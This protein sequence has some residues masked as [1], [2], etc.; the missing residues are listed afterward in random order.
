MSWRNTVSACLSHV[1][2]GRGWNSGPM[3]A[4]VTPFTTRI[5]AGPASPSGNV[6]LVVEGMVKRSVKHGPGPAAQSSTVTPATLTTA[7]G[8]PA[9]RNVTVTTFA[10][11]L[12]AK[13]GPSSQDWSEIVTSSPG[14]TI[15]LVTLPSV[16]G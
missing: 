3:S 2:S 10:A 9:G 6:A 16:E 4:A 14:A 15:G 7:C 1:V 13:P 8:S 12:V 11:A 5:S